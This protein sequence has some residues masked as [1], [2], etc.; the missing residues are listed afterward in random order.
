MRSELMPENSFSY[1]VTSGELMSKDKR[2]VAP[3][4]AVSVNLED[5]KS[6]IFSGGETHIQLTKEQLGSSYIIADSVR[7]NNDL[8]KLFLVLRAFRDNGRTQKLHVYLPYL[9]YARQDKVHAEG[10][11]DSLKWVLNNFLFIDNLEIHVEDVHNLDSIKSFPII[12]SQYVA[13]EMMLNS[14]KSVRNYDF[15][16]APDKGAIDRAYWMASRLSLPMYKVFHAE[17]VRNKETGVIESYFLVGELPNYCNVLVVDDI[18]DGGYTF[19]LLRNAL[20]KEATVALHITHGIFSKGKSRLVELY[21]TIYTV[22]DW[23]A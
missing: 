11:A 22:N 2:N 18:C 3:L 23:V 10:Q 4:D 13:H 19:E 21:N 12:R 20:P 7:T 17:K 16:I 9:P 8:V 15:V 14:H 5:V 1:T 6:F